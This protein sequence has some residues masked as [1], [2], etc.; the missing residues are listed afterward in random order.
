MNDQESIGLLSPT[1]GSGGHDFVTLT[2]PRDNAVHVNGFDAAI[3]AAVLPD[4]ETQ[5][6]AG[7]AELFIR[8]IDWP[9]VI[10]IVLVHAM[11]L[12]AP[13]FFTWPAVMVCAVLILL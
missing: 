12:G 3:A 7:A 10:W 13:F 11:A 1:T 2:V 6:G 5:D 8:G 4:P 9:V